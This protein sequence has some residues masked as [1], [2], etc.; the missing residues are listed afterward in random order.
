M[1]DE[2]D[3]IAEFTHYLLKMHGTDA[4][5]WALGYM[6]TAVQQGDAERVRGYQDAYR[7]VVEMCRTAEPSET[8]H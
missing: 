7:C 5:A 8:V 1:A 4:P 2:T 6:V 3:P